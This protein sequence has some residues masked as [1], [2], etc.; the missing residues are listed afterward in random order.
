MAAHHLIL[1]KLEDFITEE[2]LA[3]TLDER[4]RQKIARIL[5][6]DKGYAKE[7]IE[8][9]RNIHLVVDGKMGISRVDFLLKIANRVFGIIIF[10]P[11]S[12]VSRERSTI[13][14][15]RL[16]EDY[17][18]PV[19]IITNG[20]DAEIMETKSGRIIARGV[21]VIPSKEDARKIISNTEFNKISEERLDKE[22]RILYVFDVLTQKEC[23][24]FTCSMPLP[25]GTGE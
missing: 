9:R 4:I 6:E 13:A 2:T 24:D 7:E 17:E 1:G 21:D 3:D 14:A 23:D 20:E 19:A 18:V 10:G 25:P 11:G 22:R 5:V 8:V 15:A 16:V 12:L